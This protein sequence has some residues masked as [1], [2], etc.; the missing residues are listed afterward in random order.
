MAIQVGATYLEK[1]LGG[2]GVL[3]GGV[4]GVEPG[5]VLILGG[6]VVGTNAAKMAAG[7]GAHVTIMDIGL[8]RLRY[9]DDVMPANVIT[10]YSNR[11]HPERSRGRPRR[12][13]RPGP[14][15][16]RRSWC[17]APT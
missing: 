3:L 17:T 1:V 6:G 7:M 4:P 13:R 12:R 2:R 8:D 14:G 10:V 11:Q 16:R 15:R 5:N 9:L